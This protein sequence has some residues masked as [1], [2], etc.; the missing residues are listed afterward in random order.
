MRGYKTM[1]IKR[2]IQ[3][4]SSMLDEI[5]TTSVLNLPS[6][7][8]PPLEQAYDLVRFDSP[9]DISK[10]ALDTSARSLGITAST[11]IY[12][13]WA[14]FLA[15]STGWEHLGLSISLSGRTVPWSSAQSVVGSLLCTA[16]FGLSV[17]TNAGVHEWLLEV[18]K[19]TLDVLEF[20]G[21]PNALPASLT[22]DRGTITTIVL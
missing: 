6:P 1:H 21:L 15:K 2:A 14:L 5:P 4:F 7:L 16:P 22:S 3:T 20:D 8:M 13:A 9:T 11:M 19:T 10:S 17:S 18:H 12:A